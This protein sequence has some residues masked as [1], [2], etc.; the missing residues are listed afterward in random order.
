MKIDVNTR[1]GVTVV[2]L[3]GALDTKSARL[4]QGR[5]MPL[6]TDGRR[7]AISLDGVPTLSAAGL[8]LFLV[9]SRRAAATG[10]ILVLAHV[11]DEIRDLMDVT[12]FLKSFVTRPDLES[13]IDAARPPTGTDP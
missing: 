1:S 5:L 7:F 8:R 10:G 13:A 3:W 11:A 12:G 2:E 9:L 4:V 6:L